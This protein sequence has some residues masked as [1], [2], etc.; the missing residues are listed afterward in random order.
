MGKV[1]LLKYYSQDRLVRYWSLI[2]GGGG[3]GY[4]TGGGHMKFDS[5]DKGGSEKVLATLKGGHKRFWGSF[6]AVT[7]CFS[8]TERG[9]RKVSI[10]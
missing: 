5:Y 2:T 10:L 4:N 8:N 1:N 9:L 7:C 6:S 3:G